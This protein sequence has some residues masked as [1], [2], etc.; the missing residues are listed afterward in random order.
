MF[1]IDCSCY[2]SRIKAGRQ[3]NAADTDGALVAY[4]EQTDADLM[5]AMGVGDKPG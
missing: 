1:L 3:D 2:T 4:L 5:A